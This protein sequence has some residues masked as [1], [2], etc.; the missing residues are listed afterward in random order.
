MNGDMNNNQQESQPLLHETH[1]HHRTCKC[2]CLPSFFNCCF[3][4]SWTFLL[5]FTLLIFDIPK[6]DGSHDAAAKPT[7]KIHVFRTHW[8]FFILAA[9]VDLKLLIHGDGIDQWWTQDDEKAEPY[10]FKILRKTRSV[11]SFYDVVRGW[12]TSHKSTTRKLL[13]LWADLHTVSL[14]DGEGKH[15]TFILGPVQNDHPP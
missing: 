4:V 15:P 10:A 9:A 6:N 5:V 8:K 3:L 1:D 14:A 12:M 2:S 11:P 13:W 7:H